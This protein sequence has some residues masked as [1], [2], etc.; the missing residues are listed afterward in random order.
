MT[1]YQCSQCSGPVPEGSA[2]YRAQLALG[3][4]AYRGELRTD[5]L[6]C[7]SRCGGAAFRNAL[8]QKDCAHCG[9]RFLPNQGVGKPGRPA[10]FCSEKCQRSELRLLDKAMRHLARGTVPSSKGAT[11]ADLKTWIDELSD[12][13][14]L[15]GRLG[16][17]WARGGTGASV[18][19]TR[20][21]QDALQRRLNRLGELLNEANKTHAKLATAEAD[22]RVLIR[23]GPTGPSWSEL[24]LAGVGSED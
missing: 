16:R 17:A 20:E 24:L 4:P 9:S 11:A 3:G 15:A 21:A 12:A 13:I 10:A 8:A 19:P 7:S 23:R 22:A 18:E 2:N 6:L 5:L 1:N 14:Q